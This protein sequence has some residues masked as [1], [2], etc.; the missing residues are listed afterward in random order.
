MANLNLKDQGPVSKFFSGPCPDAPLS[1]A[2]MPRPFSRKFFGTDYFPSSGIKDNPSNALDE[3]WI[4]DWRRGLAMLKKTKGADPSFDRLESIH[5]EISDLESL[6]KMLWES[7]KL[8]GRLDPVTLRQHCARSVRSEEISEAKGHEKQKG[9]W[10]QSLDRLHRLRKEKGDVLNRL[11]EKYS[12]GMIDETPK[13]PNMWAV[14]IGINE[15]KTITRLRGAVRDTEMIRQYLISDLSVPADHIRSLTDA[16]AT[17]TAILSALYDLRDNEKIRRGDAILIHYSGHGASYDTREVFK[18][19][20]GS[21]EA[22]CPV[23]RGVE[24]PGQEPV[25]DISDRE[26]NLILSELAGAKGDNSTLALDCSFLPAISHYST[27]HL[28][29][30]M[31][32][33]TAPLDKS[34]HRMLLAAENNPRKRCSGSTLVEDWIP[35]LSSHVV[36]AACQDLERAWECSGDQGGDF[37]VALLKAL[38]SLP[39]NTSTYRD[40]IGS[41]GRLD[42][43]QPCA[44]GESVDNSVFN[45]SL[46]PQYHGI[47]RTSERS[48][49]FPDAHGRES[50]F[51]R[52][53]H[54]IWTF[55]W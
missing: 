48:H 27:S 35:D 47:P 30:T 36:L 39:L 23:D 1:R 5:T 11:T 55:F 9:E 10:L 19:D 54:L 49:K 41:I 46:E 18:K 40:L 4:G 2:P 7:Y 3:L 8:P 37:T 45:H 38:K 53:W 26:I 22:I 34:L 42:R 21:I 43:Q 15:Y 14:L 25:L 28:K 6:E 50:T 12:D 32:R 24:Y 52:L 44:V 13:R 33:G 31:S 17:R 29:P 51:V 20:V 16:N